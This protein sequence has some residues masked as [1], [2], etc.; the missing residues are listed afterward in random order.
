MRILLVEDDEIIGDAVRSR[1][2]RDG[3]T[4]DWI[5]NGLDMPDDKDLAAFDLVVLDIGLPGRD[6]LA[7]LRSLREAGE[8]IP[9]LLLT[10]RYELDARV[11]GLDAGADDYLVKPFAMAELTARC[12]ALS[13]RRR[14]G[15]STRLAW[16]HITFDPAAF[17]ADTAGG[18]IRFTPKVFTLLRTLVENQGRVVTRRS[19]EAHLYGWDGD[20]ESNTLEV[21]VSQIRRK[22]GADFVKTIRGVGYMVPRD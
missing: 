10:A 4:I 8:D 3:I 14:R 2:G 5:E 13:R 11:E 16:R 19:L 18:Q 20:A 1:L 22:L 6:G 17:S 9:V 21:Y 12:R 15:E 7:V